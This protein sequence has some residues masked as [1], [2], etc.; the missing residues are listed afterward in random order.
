M[1]AS[2]RSRRMPALLTSVSRRPN[3]SIARCT[4]RPA[5]AKSATFSP[6]ATASPPIPLISSTTSIAGLSDPPSPCMSPPRSLTTTLAPSARVRERVLAADAPPRSGHDDHPA[7]ADTHA[8]SLTAFGAA[9]AAGACRACRCRAG[10]APRRSRRGED[11]CS[12]RC[13]RGTTRRARRASASRRLDARLRLD[14]GHHD[15]APFVVGHADHADV[16]DRRMAEQHR[17]DLGRIDVD[18]AAD[19]EVRAA[20]GEEEVAVVVDVADVAEREVRRRAYAPVGLLGR[21]V[22]LERRP[23]VRAPSGRRCRPRPARRRRRRRRG[24][25]RG[26]AG[27]PCRPCPACAATASG[28]TSVPAP[29]GRGVVLPHDRAEPVHQ[30]LLHLDRAR[31]RAVDDE[32]RATRGRSAPS[33]R[34]AARA[35]GGTSSAPCACA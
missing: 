24:C 25:A 13:G 33:R 1:L 26:R 8:V 21:L 5:P 32:D 18:A 16:A 15:L 12:A 11:T 2:M 28:L 35:A 30:P 10:A 22:V 6:S 23:S 27:R 31:R 3:V 29:F 20:V 4:M 17:L 9:R 7:V 19:D 34:R 14:D